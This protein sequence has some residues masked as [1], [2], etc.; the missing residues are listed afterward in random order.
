MRWLLSS[1]RPRPSVVR[2]VVMPRKLAD[3]QI[4]HTGDHNNRSASILYI[5]QETQLSPRGHTTI[6]V[7]DRQR[8]I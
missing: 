2:P 5:K 6:Y 8:L 7:V 4:T 1:V 3:K